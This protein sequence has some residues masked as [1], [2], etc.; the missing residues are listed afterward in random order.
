LA[1][2]VATGEGLD[3]L[4]RRTV[5][6]LTDA[7]LPS[8]REEASMPVLRPDPV[9]E[10]PQIYRRSDGAYIV[11]DNQLERLARSLNFD[12]VDAVAYFQ[13]Q[14]DRRGVTERL[15]RAGTVAGDTVIVGA[16]EFDWDGPKL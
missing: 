1:I 8:R 7:P 6:Q 13:R 9:D 5:D 15:E 3:A 4:L 12:T 10:G 16:L 14:L 11:R 2:S